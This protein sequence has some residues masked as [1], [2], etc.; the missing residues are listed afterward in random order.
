[1][2]PPNN[3]N[4]SLDQQN[5]TAQPN[6][7]VVYRGR[8]SSLEIGNRFEQ[9]HLQLDLEQLEE[10]D[11]L[12]ELDRKIETEYFLDEAGSVVNENSS[13]DVDFRFSL[14]PYRGCAHGCSYC[15][16]RPTHEFLGFNAGIDFESKI[17]AKPNAPQ[18]FRA[19]LGRRKWQENVEP[20]MLSGVTDCYQP[21]EKKFE[22][23][24]KCLEVALE[25][26]QPM[27][28]TTKNGLIL[29]DLELLTEM[30]KL[31]LIM[32]TVSVSSLDQSLI[33]IMEPRSSS[34]QFR[35]KTIRLL[36][37]AG[38][39]VKVLVAPIIPAI[40]EQEIPEIL[41]QVADAGA[42]HAGYV[43]LRLPHSVEPVFLDWVE[44]H[45]PDRKDKIVSRV[46]SL[47]GG[48]IYDSKF[49]SRM[50][51]QGIWADQIR[52]LFQ[53]YCNKHD[54]K[55]GTAKLDCDRFRFVKGDDGPQQDGSQQMKLF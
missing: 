8:G 17:I 29:R 36:A 49:G 11:Q 12:A 52:S 21:C 47:N 23:T 27:R 50:K 1:M 9:V 55:R 48:K 25:L 31:N 16:A 18:L 10:A 28:V 38:I 7:A 19:W 45:F 24:R 3:Q 34:P 41:K 2:K 5:D 51:G 44:R 54:L 37:E 22:L 35:L 46:E 40:N 4:S 6:K 43:M 13:P 42:S 32:V 20:I 26:Q 39:P 30:T 33:R 15:Y 14:N 53:A